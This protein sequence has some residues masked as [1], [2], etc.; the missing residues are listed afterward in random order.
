MDIKH[1]LSILGFLTISIIY[2]KYKGDDDFDDDSKHYNIVKEYLLNDSS[3]AQS[4]NPILWIHM[5]YEINARNW[6]SFFSRNSC[7][8]NQPYIFLTLKTI[9]DKCGK[10]FNVCLINDSTFAKILPNWN[11]NLQIVPEPIKNKIR[12]LAMAKLLY[13]YGGMTLPNSFICFKNLR[14]VYN[15]KTSGNNMFA[16]EFL[17]RNS[18]SMLYNFF[19]SSKILGCNKKCSKMEEYIKHIEIINAVDYTDESKF[20][21]SID[22]WLFDNKNNINIIPAQQLGIRDTNNKPILIDEL[23][24]NSFIEFNNNILGVYIPADEILKRTTYQWFCRLSPKQVLD[25][26][27]MIGKY[28]VTNIEN[29]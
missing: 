13:N 18:T 26:D 29:I 8:L 1:I 17:D 4:K 16:G 5:N 27:T 21:G 23:I 19:P 3:L 14:Q 6:E 15:K 2:N 12:T 11:I 28:L 24:G 20:K 7:E 25:S 10:D 9:I 22:K